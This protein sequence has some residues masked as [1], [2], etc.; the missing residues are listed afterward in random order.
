MAKVLLAIGD[1]EGSDLAVRVAIDMVEGT[2]A[3]LHVVLCVNTTG[4]MPYPHPLAIE[5]REAFLE[6][7]KL[8]GLLKLDA[9]VAR[10]RAEGVEVEGSHYR[11][12]KPEREIARLVEEIGATV[13]IAGGR[14]AGH[15]ER[16]A[17]KLFPFV[18]DLPEK[19][20]RRTRRPV[21]AVRKQE[22]GVRH[23]A[24]G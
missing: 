10:I 11:E 21:L 13:V 7:S 12:G 20:S 17:A 16:A 18:R 14:N 6:R 1:Y 8:G 3:P 19:I 22:P 15:L 2:S 24:A 23:Q 4:S 5:R 9:E